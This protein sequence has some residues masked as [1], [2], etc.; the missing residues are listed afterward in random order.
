MIY[1]VTIG[2]WIAAILTFIFAGTASNQSK[3][4]VLNVGVF[5]LVMAVISTGAILLFGK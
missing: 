2:L 4:E 5:F 3:K 1:L